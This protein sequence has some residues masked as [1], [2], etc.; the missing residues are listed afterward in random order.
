MENAGSGSDRSTSGNQRSQGKLKLDQGYKCELRGFRKSLRKEFTKAGLDKGK[1]HWSEDKWMVKARQFLENHFH[2]TKVTEF[3]VAATVVLLYHSF[4]PSKVK[5]SNPNK[6]KKSKTPSTKKYVPPKHKKANPF[7]HAILKDAGMEL[8]KLIFENNN[9]QLV[10]R[11][12]N[13]PFIQRLW[14]VVLPAMTFVN[15]FDRS[16]Q[17]SDIRYTFCVMTSQMQTL[18]GLRVPTW[19]S[20][21]FP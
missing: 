21:Q 11:F 12:F 6:G 14:P 1:H 10:A 9:K 7:F 17:T 18:F 20:I 4:G 13:H 16:N 3:E 19:W 8:F 2:L 5:E 15:F